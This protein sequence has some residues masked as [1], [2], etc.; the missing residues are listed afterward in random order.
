[1]GLFE[2]FGEGIGV[3]T[4]DVLFDG[5]KD[6]VTLNPSWKSQ[7][8]LLQF[9]LLFLCAVFVVASLGSDSAK[10]IFKFLLWLLATSV[11]MYP[12]L[13]WV[14][15]SGFW[16]GLTFFVYFLY[17]Y[18]VIGRGGDDDNKSGSNSILAN[19]IAST[20][21][22]G[23]IL[24]YYT[25]DMVI[26]WFRRVGLWLFVFN[27]ILARGFRGGVEKETSKWKLI[28]IGMFI[29]IYFMIVI[30]FGWEFVDRDIGNKEWDGPKPIWN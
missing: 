26:W 2:D 23:L 10:G 24:W 7:F 28:S 25:W 19:L 21:M 4:R 9:V 8:V 3:Y 18:S 17:T 11:I 5:I 27:M 6:A 22:F 15:H 13:Y 29:I 20:V 12:F 30:Y 1:M 14:D 16:S